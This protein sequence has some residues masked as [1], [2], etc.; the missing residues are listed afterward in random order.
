MD[1]QQH[2]ERLLLLK[3]ETGTICMALSII[4]ETGWQMGFM[5]AMI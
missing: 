3:R 4:F 1:R 5:I 2:F